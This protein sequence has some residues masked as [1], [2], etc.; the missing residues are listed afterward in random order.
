MATTTSTRQRRDK[1]NGDYK[2]RQDLEN[3]CPVKV[4]VNKGIVA[5]MRHRGHRSVLPYKIE[6]VL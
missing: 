2:I 3:I 6:Y 4:V 5:D 1:D